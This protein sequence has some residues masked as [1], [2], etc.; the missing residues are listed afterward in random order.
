MRSLLNLTLAALAMLLSLEGTAS[1]V[2]AGADL[3]R[4]QRKISTQSRALAKLVAKKI[5]DCTDRV[6]AC[7][8]AN[9]IDAAD[10]ASCVSALATRCSAVDGL[11]DAKQARRKAVIDG[12]CGAA[13]PLG[14]VTPF[15]GGLGFVNVAA[16]CGA[17]TT[18]ELTDCLLEQTRCTAEREVFRRD[19]RAQDSLSEAGVGASFPCVGP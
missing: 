6:A 7:K 14:D 13:I 8:L 11:L 3:A 17:T 2:T 15:L 4:C 1:A 16:T 9:E 5:H 12:A 10:L 18:A 19:P